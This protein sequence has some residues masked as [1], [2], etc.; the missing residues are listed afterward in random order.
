[1]KKINEVELKLQATVA[2]P[3][4]KSFRKTLNVLLHSLIHEK[5]ILINNPLV[6]VNKHLT[7]LL[8]PVDD[9]I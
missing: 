1:M 4:E 3:P 7:N 5:Y 9:P 6:V 8:V 2:C